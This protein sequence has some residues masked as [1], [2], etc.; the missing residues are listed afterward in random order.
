MKHF[1][2]RNDSEFRA[3]SSLKNLP[4]GES[5]IQGP[6]RGLQCPTW[7]ARRPRSSTS[8]PTLP[9]S[10]PRY[11]PVFSVSQISQV[12]NSFQPQTPALEIA[13]ARSAQLLGL[14]LLAR[15]HHSG[16]DR[17]TIRDFPRPPL[18]KS[19]G[20]P[21]HFQSDHCI[22]FSALYLLLYEIVF[23]CLLI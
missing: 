17:V 5:E 22:F 15:A 9:T 6:C 1:P 18:W 21:S 13:S 3:A 23:I 20:D 11:T 14:F 4:A 10:T 12:L 16:L 7:P 19:S 8:F 2:N